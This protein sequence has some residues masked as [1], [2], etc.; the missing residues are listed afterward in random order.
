ME[1]GTNAITSN[2]LVI[3]QLLMPH[4]FNLI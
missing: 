2:L 4:Y 3:K 1:K